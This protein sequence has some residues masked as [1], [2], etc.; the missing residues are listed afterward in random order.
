[1]REKQCLTVDYN[2]NN[3]KSLNVFI[4]FRILEVSGATINGIFGN[5]NSGRVLT[6]KNDRFIDITH[7]KPQ[8]IVRLGYGSGHENIIYIYIYINVVV[9]FQHLLRSTLLYRALYYGKIETQ[10]SYIYICLDL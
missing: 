2:L 6:G 3:N 8:R 9:Y 5:D 1:L 7:A 10:I 4:V